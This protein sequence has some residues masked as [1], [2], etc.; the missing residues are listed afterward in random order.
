[1]DTIDHGGNQII[2][3]LVTYNTTIEELVI[4]L[5]NFL[6]EFSIIIS[7]NST[8]ITTTKEIEGFSNINRCHY[9]GMNGNRGIAYA[10]NRAIELAIDL[11]A[12]YVVL[13][14]DDSCL[15]AEAVKSLKSTFEKLENDGI[16][17]GAISA[18]AYS[19]SGRDLSNSKFKGGLIT[20]CDL[21]NSSGTLIPV[22]LFQELGLFDEDLFIDLVDFDWGF[23]AQYNKYILYI[24]NDVLLRHNLGDGN[25]SILGVEIGIPNPIRHYYQSRNYIKLLKKTHVPV[26]WKIKSGLYFCLKLIIFPVFINPRWIR[27]KFL[28]KGIIDGSLGRSGKIM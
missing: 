12:Q 23:K 20:R 1:M 16:R 2:G 22:C 24:A 17:I 6:S 7:D 8:S 14:D 25:A 19:L 28:V 26:I 13:L 5:E 9:L 18:R 3:I 27:L 4:N 21:L 15:T 11:G 10:Q